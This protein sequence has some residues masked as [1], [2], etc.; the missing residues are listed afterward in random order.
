MEVIPAVRRNRSVTRR[1]KAHDESHFGETSNPIRCPRASHLIDFCRFT[2][3]D[4]DPFWHDRR[5]A[6][7]ECDCEIDRRRKRR[8]FGCSEGPPRI[9]PL[10][11]R[12]RSPDCQCWIG[13]RF[14]L[15]RLSA[16]TLS[17]GSRR[18]YWQ[19]CRGTNRRLHLPAL[20]HPMIRPPR[21][22]HSLWHPGG[23]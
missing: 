6:R 16:D 5:D 1:R 9:Q 22:L 21:L 14:Q 18:F 12:L 20:W 8:A 19:A 13:E 4:V 10:V 7:A 2:D 11:T 17:V 3:L 23:R 15:F